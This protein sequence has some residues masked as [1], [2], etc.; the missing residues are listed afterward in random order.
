[1]IFRTTFRHRRSLLPFSFPHCDL[2]SGN[3][4]QRLGPK[5]NQKTVHYNGKSMILLIHSMQMLLPRRA[6]REE[7]TKP[8]S[9]IRARGRNSDHDEVWV[10][11]FKLHLWSHTRWTAKWYDAKGGAFRSVNDCVIV[12]AR[13]LVCVCVSVCWKCLGVWGVRRRNPLPRGA[14]G[15]WGTKSQHAFQ[16]TRLIKVVH[17]S[18]KPKTV[19]TVELSQ[20]SHRCLGVVRLVRVVTHDNATENGSS[21]MSYKRLGVTANWAKGNARARN[22]LGTVEG[23]KV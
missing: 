9:L 1:M 13:A 5:R 3:G 19:A 14:R 22:L 10:Y 2:E 8:A 6:M 16:T 23:L 17:H 7:N 4:V 20:Q 21:F 12:C 15:G 18:R 11:K